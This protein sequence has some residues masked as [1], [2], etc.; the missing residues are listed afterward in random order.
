MTKKQHKAWTD[1]ETWMQG[2]AQTYQGVTSCLIKFWKTYKHDEAGFFALK[3]R[4]LRIVAKQINFELGEIICKRQFAKSVSEMRKAEL[5]AACWYVF[6]L[7]DK[8]PRGGLEE[9]RPVPESSRIVCLANKENVAW[10]TNLGFATQSKARTFFNYLL[11]PI[12][13]DTSRWMVSL[14]KSQRCTGFDWECKVWGINNGILQQLITRES[15][16]CQSDATPIPVVVPELIPSEPEPIDP[17]TPT[18]GEAETPHER[19][20]RYQAMLESTGY[21][22]F[23]VR[24]IDDDPTLE[25]VDGKVW[26]KRDW[27]ERVCREIRD[28][29]VL[30]S[31]FPK[32]DFDSLTTSQRI[33]HNNRQLGTIA[34]IDGQYKVC[35]ESGMLLA[36]WYAIA[37]PEEGVLK[38]LD[39]AGVF[40]Y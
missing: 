38:L 35:P 36:K 3:I 20:A 17:N 24:K 29:A 40:A 7:R 22:S 9:T 21:A 39:Y 15:K 19:V 6:S 32:G 5:A 13:I 8:R 28:A 10:T 14:R 18:K 25:L 11:D 33:Q 26:W 2:F 1:A 12:R 31:C 4:Q 30:N 34:W 16:R 37:N 23:L 27:N